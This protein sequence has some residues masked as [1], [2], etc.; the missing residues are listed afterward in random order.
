MKRKTVF[1]A[2]IPKDIQLFEI[3]SGVVIIDDPKLLK[4]LCQPYYLLIKGE[5]STCNCSRNECGKLRASSE[6]YW[7]LVKSERKGIQIK[8]LQKGGCIALSM[9]SCLSEH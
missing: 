6:R 2:G 1:Y 9:T 3:K 7:K 4:K 5:I 8:G